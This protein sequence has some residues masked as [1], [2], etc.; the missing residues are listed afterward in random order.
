[1]LVVL[2]VLGITGPAGAAPATAVSGDVTFVDWVFGPFVEDPATG[3]WVWSGNTIT[4]A[5]TGDLVGTYTLYSTYSGK[6]SNL[7]DRITGTANFSGTLKG[8]PISWSATVRG[9]GKRDPAYEFAGRN[10]WKSTLFGDHTGLIAIHQ[11]YNEDLGLDHAVY[12]GELK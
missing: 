2:L 8:K 10:Y 3:T 6:L 9:S 5:L 7:K 12:W 1:L 4:W 11:H